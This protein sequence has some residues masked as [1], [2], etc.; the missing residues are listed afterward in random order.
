MAEP[1]IVDRLRRLISEELADLIEFRRDLHAHPELMYQEVRTAG[2]V[3]A[4]LEESTIEFVDD[5]AGGTGVLA[6]LPGKDTDRAVALRADMDALPIQEE[7]DRPYASTVDGRMHACGHDGHTTICLGAAR[8]LKRLS[9]EVGGL[10]NPVKFVFQP[11]EEGGGGGERMVQDGV[12]GAELLGPRVSRMFGLH[13]WPML[14]L[15][16]IATRPGPLLAATDLFTVTVR[17]RGGHAA[18]PHFTNDPI[19]GASE[20]VGALQTIA[21]R[22]VDPIDSIVVSVTK[23]QAGTAFNIIPDEATFAG[24]MRTLRDE[25]RAFGRERFYE[26]VERVA[27]A[28]R[29]EASVDWHVGYPVTRN[30]PTAVTEFFDA[31]RGAVGAERAQLYPEPCMG[32]EDFSYYCNEVP[33][34]FFLLG[35]QRAPDEPY[36]MVHTPRFDFND[37]SIALGVEM[38]CRLAL[39]MGARDAGEA[40]NERVPEEV[41]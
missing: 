39:G 30:H 14:P 17:G 23:V 28:H 20:I 41:S 34:C 31:A 9:D 27:S 5:L 12:L 2:R 25:T 1:E 40:S 29:C 11:A 15:G 35:Q 13:C 4:S 22:N 37:D 7:S 33:A 18:S 3:R 21:S 38:F 36:P 32:G 8:V 24:T 16:V 10:P 26:I 19:V 6:F